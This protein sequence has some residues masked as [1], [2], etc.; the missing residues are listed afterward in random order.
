MSYHL[1][2]YL[3]CPFFH[4]PGVK[5]APTGSVSS[6]SLLRRNREWIRAGPPTGLYVLACYFP[7]SI[8]P[9]DDLT[10]DYQIL[11]GL[12]TRDYLRGLSPQDINLVHRP[13]VQTGTQV[14]SLCC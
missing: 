4:A 1:D 9:R 12:S 3:S 5:L 6:L 10:K 14:I 8:V 2:K 7:L 13:Q 11:E